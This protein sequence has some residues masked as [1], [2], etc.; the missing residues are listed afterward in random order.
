MVFIILQKEL[1]SNEI[2]EISGNKNI[3]YFSDLD[4][5]K[6]AFIDSIEVINNLDLLITADTALAHLSATIGKKTWI[7]LPYI[8]GWRWFLEE[9]DTR[10][11]PNV[12][13]YRQ[14]KTEDWSG[15]FEIIKRNLKKEFN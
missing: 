1:S 6:Q 5:G 9:K 13:L 11:Y 7:A 3:I 14:K 4:D 8:A 12:T 15:V 10:W 2:K